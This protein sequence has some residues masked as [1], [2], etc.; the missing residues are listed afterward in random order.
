MHEELQERVRAAIEQLGYR[1]NALARSLRRQRSHT[2]GVV[3]PD[4]TNPYFAELAK[5]I[6][7]EAATADYSVILG[8]SMDSADTEGMYLQTFLARQVDGLILA[9]ALSTMI[10]PDLHGTPLLLVDRAITGVPADVVIS[11]NREG[12]RIAVR[13][14]LE[15]GHRRIAFVGGPIH[16]TVA[17]DRHRGCVDALAEAGHALDSAL[18][19]HGAFDY[20]AGRDAL[21]MF[22]RAAHR[23]T[24]VFASSDQQAIGLLR[25]CSDAGIGVPGDV[26]VV[27]FDDIPLAELV[28]PRLTTV[29]Q[30]LESLGSRAVRLVLRRV[31]DTKLRPKKLTLPVTLAIRE[32]TARLEGVAH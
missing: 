6:E 5:A 20:A 23:P 21:E 18:T 4:I 15:L 8:N 32:S 24:A 29:S 14:L 13:H 27:G 7:S 2:L 22:L 1:P 28:S 11:D 16:L 25:A 26:S 31:N 19:F 9:P 12:A 10:L 30:P 17:Q 3:V